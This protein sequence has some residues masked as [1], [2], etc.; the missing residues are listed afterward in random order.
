MTRP[1]RSD[2]ANA[3]YQRILDCIQELHTPHT[4]QEPLRAL[5]RGRENFDFL[6][7]LSPRGHSFL[8]EMLHLPYHHLV[9]KAQEKGQP[10]NP[11]AAAL[12]SQL[13][14]DAL[15]NEEP[16]RRTW[17]AHPAFCKAIRAN[18]QQEAQDTALTFLEEA[19]LFGD[20]PILLRAQGIYE[21]Y[22]PELLPD[23]LTTT[24]TNNEIPLML[25][26]RLWEA[27]TFERL[28]AI[29]ADTFPAFDPEKSHELAEALRIRAT[30]QQSF[31]HRL[32]RSAEGEFVL[33][34]ASIIDGFKLAVHAF[35]VEGV[36]AE[37]QQQ[38]KS[39][40][41]EILPESGTK[42][43]LR[44]VAPELETRAQQLLEAAI[45]YVTG[46]AA[47]AKSH[48]DLPDLRTSSLSAPPPPPL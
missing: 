47:A 26:L 44:G 30:P 17:T 24:N 11:Q 7:E 5:L 21:G 35:G 36:R 37:M 10:R 25:A 31:C 43:E 14:L 6:L 41:Y 18:L 19:L 9:E 33:T 46:A 28:C 39:T 29:Y 20:A 1:Y 13:L 40:G 22:A 45:R 16:D 34:E 8:M 4:H 23:H 48:P 12:R 15:F 38:M 42:I 3:L 32:L 27:A 2:E